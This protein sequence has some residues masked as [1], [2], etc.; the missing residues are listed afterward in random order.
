MGIVVRGEFGFRNGPMKMM[1]KRD[2]MI[3][4]LFAVSENFTFG[5]K[6]DTPF[7]LFCVSP[8]VIVA[9]I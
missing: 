1:T 5:W 7:F 6:Y 3:A 4:R 8:Y 2:E 9:D